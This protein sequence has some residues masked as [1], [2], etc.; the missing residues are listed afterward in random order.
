MSVRC[1]TGSISRRLAARRNPP[2]ITS[3]GSGSSPVTSPTIV[4]A[5]NGSP[6]G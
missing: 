5:R 3:L 2:A 6:R 4:T 1:G